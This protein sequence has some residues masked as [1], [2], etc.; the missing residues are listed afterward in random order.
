MTDEQKAQSEKKINELKKKYTVRGFKTT[1]ES[2]KF[3]KKMASSMSSL[4]NIDNL[5]DEDVSKLFDLFDEKL[6]KSVVST[7]LL[8][9]DGDK[10]VPIDYEK[11]FIADINGLMIAFSLCVKTLME[12][13]NGGGKQEAQPS[14]GMRVKSKK[15]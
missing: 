2:F 5:K 14:K 7:Y 15:R 10:R 3:M 11:E 8:K 4:E 6:I 9:K 12:K 13:L 1:S